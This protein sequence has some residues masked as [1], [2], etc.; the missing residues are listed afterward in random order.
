MGTDQ[1]YCPQVEFLILLRSGTKQGY[2]L[3]ITVLKVLTLQEENKITIINA[4][5]KEIKYSLSIIR[6][7]A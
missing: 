3:F 1:S 7:Y 2:L 5:G 4:R 6:L